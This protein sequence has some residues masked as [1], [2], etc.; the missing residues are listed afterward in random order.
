MYCAAPSSSLFILLIPFLLIM[1]SWSGFIFIEIFLY[2]KSSRNSKPKQVEPEDTET[3]QTEEQD[4]KRVFIQEFLHL[5]AFESPPG[6]RGWKQDSIQPLPVS[7]YSLS[8]TRAL[9]TDGLVT[10]IFH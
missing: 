3:I 5:G 7:M 10:P 9:S 2:L 8:S 4:A 1:E 6:R